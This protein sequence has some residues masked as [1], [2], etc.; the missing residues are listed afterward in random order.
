MQTLGLNP[1]LSQQLLGDLAEI[2]NQLEALKGNNQKPADVGGT[3]EPGM[4]FSDHLMEG[5]NQV[6]Q[7][8]KQAD[9]MATDLATGKSQNIHE[10]MLKATEAE[11][12]FNLMIQLRNKALEAYQEV[13]RM[14]V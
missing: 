8:Q 5:V 10:T 3:S 6:D 13:M 11:L 4:S 9:A 2:K 1:K 14:Q 12:S 7:V